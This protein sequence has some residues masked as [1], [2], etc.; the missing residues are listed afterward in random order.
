MVLYDYESAREGKDITCGDLDKTS[1]TSLLY[2][3]GRMDPAL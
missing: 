2:A 3:E 1:Y